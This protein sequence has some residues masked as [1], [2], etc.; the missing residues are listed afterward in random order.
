MEPRLSDVVI[1]TPN[2]EMPA[3]VAVPA[4]A[5]PWPGVVVVHDFA[6][7][8]HDLRN[9]A[10]WLAREGFLAAAPDLYYWGSR[11]RCLWTI[12]RE[13]TAGSGRTVADID[14]ARDWLSARADCTGKIGIIGFCMGGGYALALAAGHGYAVCSTN[15]G[16]CPADAEQRLSSACPVV[17]SYGG[18]DRSPMGASAGARLERTL[19]AL[20]VDHDIEVYPEAGHGFIN[21]HDPAESTPLL[22][23]LNK[24]SG[25]RYHEPSAADAHQRIAAF[26]SRYLTAE[27]QAHP[28]MAGS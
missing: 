2:G 21:N 3:Y 23:I 25:T 27:D 16:G 15:Y 14:A 12:M 28:P 17:G 7:M 6:G 1:R 5:G 26:F 19:T 10:G 18:K 9:Q 11:L 22:L 13:V 8:T 20:G 24:V 4:G